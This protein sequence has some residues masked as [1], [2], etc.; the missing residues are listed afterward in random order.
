MEETERIIN[1]DCRLCDVANEAFS[2]GDPI[3]NERLVIKVLRSLPERFNI[4]I[5]A[6]YE[7]RDTTKLILDDLI[8]S[9]KTFETNLY[10]QKNA[11]GQ[12]I[13]FQV[14]NDSYNDLFQLSQEVNESNLGEDFISLITKKFD[15]Y[16]K[17]MR[18]KKKS[19]QP[20]KLPSI[21]SLENLKRLHLLKDNF[22]R[23]MN[24]RF[25]LMSKG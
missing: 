6:I 12:V 13:A 17:K 9:L 14:Y 7:D 23:G 18:E 24:E 16:L 15:D 19:S 3:S 22:D 25:K 8:I 10:L 5:G 4:K 1:Y 11:N 21:T 20:L 2:L